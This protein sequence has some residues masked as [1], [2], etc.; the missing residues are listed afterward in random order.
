MDIAELIQT[1]DK[2]IQS[3]RELNEIYNEDYLE[4]E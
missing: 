4:G 1:I 2:T 3:I